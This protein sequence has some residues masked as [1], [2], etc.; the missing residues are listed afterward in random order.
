MSL[1]STSFQSLVRLDLTQISFDPVM[2]FT[3][4]K[5]PL[6]FTLLFTSCDGLQYLNI[7]ASQLH[8]LHIIDSHNIDFSFLKS[9]TELKSLTI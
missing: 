5:A 8:G 9:Y 2:M 7:F 1:A 6:L 4:L 3:I